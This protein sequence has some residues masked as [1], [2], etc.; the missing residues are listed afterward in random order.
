MKYHVWGGKVVPVVRVVGVGGGFG[1]VAVWVDTLRR[2][3]AKSTVM[4]EPSTTS[5]AATC[6]GAC[7]LVCVCVFFVWQNRLLRIVY[8]LVLICVFIS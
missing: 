1:V 6:F 7:V 4:P 5:T 2:T 8:V 3:Y